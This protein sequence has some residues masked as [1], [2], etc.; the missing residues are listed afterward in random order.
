MHYRYTSYIYRYIYI[1]VRTNVCAYTFDACH[2]YVWHYALP[3]GLCTLY[4]TYNIQCTLYIVHCIQCTGSK[5]YPHLYIYVSGNVYRCS[6]IVV[7]VKLK[8][9]IYVSIIFINVRMCIFMCMYM[10]M[11]MGMRMGM[12]MSMIKGMCACRNSTISREV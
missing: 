7:A 6:S 11:C 3:P 8:L 10:G 2:T 12:C 5:A 1:Y 4:S 9:C